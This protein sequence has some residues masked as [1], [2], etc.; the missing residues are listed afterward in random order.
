MREHRRWL[1][2]RAG[3]QFRRSLAGQGRALITDRNSGHLAVIDTRKQT[4]VRDVV[5][6]E[7]YGRDLGALRPFEKLER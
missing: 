7:T 1:L 6:L 3:P 2:A 5:D 4:L